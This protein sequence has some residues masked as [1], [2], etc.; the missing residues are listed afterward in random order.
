MMVHTLLPKAGKLK[1]DAVD[2]LAT[3]ICH[4]YMRVTTNRLKQ[5]QELVK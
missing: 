4:A 2:A 1:P 5:L 3:A